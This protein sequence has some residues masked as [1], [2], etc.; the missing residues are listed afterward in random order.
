[1]NRNRTF[2]YTIPYYLWL[3]LFVIAPVVLLVIQSFGN[4]SGHFTLKIMQLILAQVLI[5]A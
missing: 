4:L 1:M 3:G 5:Y 2:S